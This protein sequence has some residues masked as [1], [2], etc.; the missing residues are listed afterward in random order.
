MNE[1]TKKISL[2]KSIKGQQK[3][4]EAESDNIPRGREAVKKAILEATEKLLLARSPHEISVREIAKQANVKHSLV[5]RH[6][7][8][9][10]ELIMA[11]S[12]TKHQAG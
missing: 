9:K 7:G 3:V 10:D 2:N 4:N 6:F 11:I 12:Q 8:T 1:G 5:H